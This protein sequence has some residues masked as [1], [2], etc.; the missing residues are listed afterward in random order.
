MASDQRAAAGL[1]DSDH[2]RA[3]RAP[4]TAFRDPT[5]HDVPPRASIEFR[6]IAYFN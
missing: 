1:H 6:T 5:V 4:H 3:W 2:S